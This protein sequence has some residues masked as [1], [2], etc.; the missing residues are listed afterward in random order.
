MR[1]RS[2]SA[3]LAQGAAASPSVHET[4]D[5][6][7]AIVRQKPGL[8]IAAFLI[9][10]ALFVAVFKFP[11]ILDYPNHYARM[12][13]LAGGINT[14]PFHEIY[15]LDWNRTFTN[16]GIDLAAYWLG[17]MIGVSLLARIFLF[18]AIVLPPLG[19]ITLH[20]RLHGGGYYWQIGILYFAWCATLIGGFINFQIGL[21]M[22]LLF[23]GADH[24]LQSRKPAVLFVWRLFAG[25][26]L[27]VMHIFSLGFY[28]ALVC[29][30]EF[31]PTM[32]ALRSPGA[33]LRLCG[34]LLIAMLACALPAICLFFYQPVLPDG[35]GGLDAS[36]NDSVVLILANLMS[37]LWSYALL[38]DML[39]MI[40]PI[41]ICTYAV[42]TRR[43]TIHAGMA[44][45]AAGLLLLSC[46]AP[47]HMLGTGWISWRFPIM[48]ALAAMVMICPLPRLPRRQA[49]IVMLVL[50]AAVL[51]RTAWI[52][53][54][55]RQGD[56]DAA[57]VRTVLASVPEGAAILPIM[58]QPNEH[59]VAD[60]RYF[61]W[62]QDTF[63]HLPT[64]AVPY[65]HAFVPTLF[66]ARGKQ[67]LTILPPWSGIAVPE[68]NL[69]S[70]SLLDCPDEIRAVSGIASYLSDWRRHFDFILLVNADAE[71]RFGGDVPQGVR[72]AAETPFAKLYAV[73][74][75]FMP[76]AD[77][78][79]PKSCAE[80]A[81]AN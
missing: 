1:Q 54:N 8:A 70:I 44:I 33:F 31:S 81:A 3:P 63:R 74:K 49:L 61:A 62:N 66:T 10:V 25:L 51:G 12:W 13:L 24:A 48:T 42:R 69:F 36:W 38:A 55:W 41:L 80:L 27:T 73:D 40:P 19:A 26:L 21:G 34:R 14:P 58:R 79:R 18:M 15:A 20:R 2:A 11:P 22:A 28:M 71:D 77:A 7:A 76:A 65:A 16:V 32:A 68:G 29:G 75:G 4:V 59:G 56:A 78:P 17:P 52:G 64:L 30:L 72:L 45:A 46:I 37:A 57:A 23:A 67:P 35:G 47:R 9:L 53:F 6:D 60:H 39:L 5:A 50:S 43:L